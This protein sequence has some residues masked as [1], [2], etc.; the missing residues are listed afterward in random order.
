MEVFKRVIL[1]RVG[2][3][4]VPVLVVTLPGEAPRYI[5]DTSDIIDE[6]ERLCTGPSQQG[7]PGV[8]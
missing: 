2:W 8:G 4:V 3:A 6:V 5:Q 1:P 7:R